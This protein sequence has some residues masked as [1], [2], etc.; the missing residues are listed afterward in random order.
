[1]KNIGRLLAG[2][3]LLFTLT[4]CG[5][6]ALTANNDEDASIQAPPAATSAPK[7]ES[8]KTST[9]VASS[10]PDTQPVINPFPSSVGSGGV[11]KLD[12]I[13]TWS[14][15]YL[16]GVYQGA[17]RI[18][19]GGGG[20]EHFDFYPAPGVR[21]V[22]YITPI[23]EPVI[24]LGHGSAWEGYG[25][26]CANFDWV[27]DTTRYAKDRYI[28]DPACTNP[29]QCRNNG[30]SGLVVD[31]R[32][33]PPA[34]VANL[35]NLSPELI[36]ALLT[37]HQPKVSLRGQPMPLPPQAST[38][39]TAPAPVAPA[40]IVPPAPYVP[41]APQPQASAPPPPPPAPAVDCNAQTRKMSTGGMVDSVVSGPAVVTV[42]TNRGPQRN[43]QN[44]ALPS[45]G[46]Q[47]SKVIVPAGETW[48]FRDASGTI[49]QYRAGCMDAV[50][51]AFNQIGLTA[52][53]WAEL[54]AARLVY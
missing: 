5:G 49:N 40:N 46:Q 31:L 48:T 33:N 24:G 42:W 30:H 53:S 51:A 17:Q 36:T 45:W 50:N 29:V 38:A 20:V 3:L 2:V 52:R 25:P 13:G 34:V 11:C 37:A 1:M 23:G 41:P 4:A 47:E 26:D 7:A 14:E 18:E 43:P 12:K 15:I 54:N 16:N 10:T 9:P 28:N 19:I 6:G 8:T 27:A 32:T 21:A 44:L 22:S 35:G 39:Q